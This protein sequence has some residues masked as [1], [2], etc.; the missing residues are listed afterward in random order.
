MSPSTAPEPL[1]RR[2]VSIAEAAVHY[3]VHRD[4]IRR[5]IDRGEMYAERIGPRRVRV[6]LN[7]VHAVPLGPTG[8]AE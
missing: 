6:D 4:T 3:G 2:W 5:M 8:G 1:R 7:S